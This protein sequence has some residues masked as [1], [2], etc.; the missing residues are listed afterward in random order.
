MYDLK[1]RV[2]G[3]QKVGLTNLIWS[4]RA[5]ASLRIAIN[6]GQLRAPTT[7]AYVRIMSGLFCQKALSSNEVR[8]LTKEAMIRDNLCLNSA[9]CFPVLAPAGPREIVPL[10]CDLSTV[11]DQRTLLFILKYFKAHNCSVIS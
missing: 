8:D 1:R 5:E 2:Y 7:F 3:G 4:S 10:P 11:P 6:Q 9:R